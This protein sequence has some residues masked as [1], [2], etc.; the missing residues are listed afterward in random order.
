M[1]LSPLGQD[2]A[3]HRRRSCSEVEDAVPVRVEA[4]ATHER[5][6]RCAR[7]RRMGVSQGGGAVEAEK[8]KKDSPIRSVMMGYFLP[9]SL[10]RKMSTSSFP[11]GVSHKA[12]FAKASPSATHPRVRT[13]VTPAW[14]TATIGSSARTT[15]PISKFRLATR[16]LPLPFISD[17]AMLCGTRQFATEEKSRRMLIYK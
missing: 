14:A 11:A 8:A 17:A 16:P 3:F 9:S 13:P 4:A 5:V 15:S 6:A 10:C 12:A 7:A 2:V 1:L